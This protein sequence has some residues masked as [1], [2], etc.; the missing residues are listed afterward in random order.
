M[1]ASFKAI[2]RKQECSARGLRGAEANFFIPEVSRF[3]LL[4][5]FSVTFSAKSPLVL[6]IA[7]HHCRETKAQKGVESDSA[8]GP[9]VETLVLRLSKG[10]CPQANVCQV[11]YAEAG[12]K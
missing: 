7:L 8:A 2:F 1:L 12:K 5:L 9:F 4:L 11:F 3:L 6:L 10:N